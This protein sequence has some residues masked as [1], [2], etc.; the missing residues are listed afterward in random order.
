M[1]TILRYKGY[2]I[3]FYMA[4]GAEPVHVHVTAAD[5]RGA[6]FWIPAQLEW[7]K[8]LRSHELREIVKILVKNE[9]LIYEKWN[10]TFKK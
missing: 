1:R 3:S 10:E 8:G 7:N 4:D 9:K 5:G 2:R 6:K